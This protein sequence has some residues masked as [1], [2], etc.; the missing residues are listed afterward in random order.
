MR[1]KTTRWGLLVFTAFLIAGV[2][3]S[4]TTPVVP[5][6]TIASAANVATPVPPQPTETPKPTQTPPP[7]K[8]EIIAT[9]T[10][11]DLPL[12]GVSKRVTPGEHRQ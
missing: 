5:T 8:D 4:P 7:A 11:P 1:N 9:Y 12:G 2:A 10:L 6:S 3:C